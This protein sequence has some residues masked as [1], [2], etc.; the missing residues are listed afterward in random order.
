MTPNTNAVNAIATAP[1]TRFVCAEIAPLP[2]PPAALPVVDGADCVLV[3]VTVVFELVVPGAP[4]SVVV[5]SPSVTV[6]S[7]KLVTILDEL[8]VAATELVVDAPEAEV[9]PAVPLAEGAAAPPR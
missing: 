5:G 8:V 1:T 6:V 9:E 2:F 3:W 7:L 4:E